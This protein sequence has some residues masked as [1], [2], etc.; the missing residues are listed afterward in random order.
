MRQLCEETGTIATARLTAAQSKLRSYVSWSCD[1]EFRHGLLSRADQRVS[2]SVDGHQSEYS[3]NCTTVWMSAGKLSLPEDGVAGTVDMLEVLPNELAELYKTPEK[4][5][6]GTPKPKK[7]RP[8]MGVDPGEYINVIK[9]LR[10]KGLVELRSTKPK[11]MNGIFA[12]PKKDKGQRLI[13]WTPG[14]QMTGLLSVQL[15]VL[16]TLGN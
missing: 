12:V 4:L 5:L 1:R 9:I 14:R 3:K 6:D 15:V 8:Y 16:P 10:E 7:I 13:N 2:R 11:V